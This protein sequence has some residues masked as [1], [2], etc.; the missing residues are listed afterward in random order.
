MSTHKVWITEA[1]LRRAVDAV[2]TS[3]GC[4]PEEVESALQSWLYAE[5]SEKPS[6]G[7]DRLPW[8]REMIRSGKIVP[9]RST[10]VTRNGFHVHIGGERAMGYSAA[11]LAVREAIRA[12]AVGGVSFV[13]VSDCYPTGCMGQYV[14]AIADAGMIGIAISHSPPRVAPYGA[15]SAV[16]GTTGHSFGFPSAGGVPYVYDSSVGTATNGEVMKAFR[17]GAPVPPR[18]FRSVDG[19]EA[20]SYEALMAANGTFNGVIGVAGGPHAHRISGFAGSLELLLRLALLPGGG[21][22]VAENYS[23]FIAVDPSYFGDAAV[24]RELVQSLQDVVRSARPEQDGAPVHFAGEQSWHRRRRNARIGG[25]H[26]DAKLH[27]MLTQ[28]QEGAVE[29]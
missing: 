11:D 28:G 20:A 4:T 7:I 12:A 29:Q 16:Y 25:I 1:N 15:T 13:T 2:L 23:I 10:S 17:D 5:Y 21:G 18:L 8:L 22:R 9:G 14:E 3:E 24:Y 27:Q 26:L 19:V 6:H